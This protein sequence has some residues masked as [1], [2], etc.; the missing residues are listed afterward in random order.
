VACHNASAIFSSSVAP[1]PFSMNLA[2]RKSSGSNGTPGLHQQM[3][4]SSPASAVMSPDAC[5][6]VVY[7]P[8]ISAFPI[9]S[10]DF[11][12]GCSR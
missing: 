3:N 8:P 7:N 1:C 6:M 9:S 2:K 4:G 12:I 10:I 11:A 5:L